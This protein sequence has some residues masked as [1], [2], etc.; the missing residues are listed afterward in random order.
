M[1][2]YVLSHHAAAEFLGGDIT[3]QFECFDE[4]VVKDE[5]IGTCRVTISK[6]LSN[7]KGEYE[8]VNTKFQK[9]SK[10]YQNSGILMVPTTFWNI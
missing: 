9:K 8:L 2:K 7:P 5:L 10:N 6:I 3:L 4:D 1:Y